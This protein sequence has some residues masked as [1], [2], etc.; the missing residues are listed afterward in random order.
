MVIK[1]RGRNLAVVADLGVHR[2]LPPTVE[3]IIGKYLSGKNS[4]FPSQVN[5]LKQKLGIS[6]APRA[7]GPTRT[8]RKKN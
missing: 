7:R 3:G 8:K 6:L 1:Q 4:S 2:N 5:Q